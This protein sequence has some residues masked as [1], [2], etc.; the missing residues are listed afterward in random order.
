MEAFIQLF[1]DGLIYR[2]ESLVNWSCSLKSAISDIE[3]DSVSIN[4]HTKLNVPGYNKEVVF[5]EIYNIAYNVS[6]GNEQILVATT[7]PETILGDVAVAVHPNDERYSHL[8]NNETRLW[9][10]F[11]NEEIPLIFDDAVTPSLGTGAVKITPAHNK[12]DFE[13][14]QRHNLPIISVI[15][16]EGNIVKEFD[17]Y[18]GLPRFDARDKLLN[19]LTNLNLFHSK[20]DHKLEL[21]I[22]SR[23][24]DVIELLIKPQWFMKCDKLAA[25]ATKVVDNNVLK[26][27]PPRF[28]KEWKNWLSKPIDWC[29]SRQIWWGHQI[30]AYHCIYENKN[31]WI[32]AHNEDEARE[33]ALKQFNVAGCDPKDIE[34]VQDEDVLDT[35]FSSGILPFSVY[36][37]PKNKHIKHDSFPLDILVSGHDIL[38]F[39]IARMVMLSLYFMQDV[40]FHNVL[41]HGIVC[42]EEGKKMSKSRGNVITPTQI[43]NGASSTVIIVILSTL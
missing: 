9:H 36:D 20:S 37:W 15:D 35:W 3:V 18:A 14:A 39:W 30:P 7:R 28:E 2:K 34:I 25:L 8:R 6:N 1:E 38:F 32:A 43:F 27:H 23:S 40:P 13:I 42:D 11:R 16:S 29:L 17:S 41:L 22:C 21:P 26:I 5:G 31:I 19:D 24:K 4:G 33:K 12:V 10:P